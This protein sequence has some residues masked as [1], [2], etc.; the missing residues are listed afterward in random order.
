VQFF[1]CEDNIPSEQVFIDY[2]LTKTLS[3]GIVD[4]EDVSKN[5]Y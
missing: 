4:T 1:F 3:T 2:E 5:T